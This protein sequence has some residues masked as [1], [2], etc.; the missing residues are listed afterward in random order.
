MFVAGIEIKPSTMHVE[1][2]SDVVT[3]LGFKSPRLH[4]TRCAQYPPTYYCLLRRKYFIEKIS[5]A[6]NPAKHLQLEPPLFSLPPSLWL[7]FRSAVEDCRQH[8]PSSRSRF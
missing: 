3:G 4:S 5:Q 6:K 8:C 2:A 1:A 7:R